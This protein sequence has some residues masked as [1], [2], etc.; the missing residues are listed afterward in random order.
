M[1]G[2]DR[3]CCSSIHIPS[4]DEGAY[5]MKGAEEICLLDTLYMIWLRY[6]WRRAKRLGCTAGGESCFDLLRA[7]VHW[8]LHDDG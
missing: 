3:C 5:G 1:D 7:I 8:K 6:S 4:D 2:F